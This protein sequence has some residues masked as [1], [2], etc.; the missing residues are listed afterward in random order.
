MGIE[1]EWLKKIKS[2][3]D[4][5]F[6]NFFLA[7]VSLYDNVKSS[8]QTRRLKSS[9]KINADFAYCTAENSDSNSCN[10][11]SAPSTKSIPVTFLLQ[12]VSK[13]SGKMEFIEPRNAAFSAEKNGVTI[14]Q[15]HITFSFSLS[16]QTYPQSWKTIFVHLLGK[17]NLS[18]RSDNNTEF[19]SQ[20]ILQTTTI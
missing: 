9:R 18:V 15:V 12:W 16:K 1:L 2:Q 8:Y 4:K 14:S 13:P 5:R 20:E 19:C 17:S 7:D 11:R 3:T 10:L 6:N